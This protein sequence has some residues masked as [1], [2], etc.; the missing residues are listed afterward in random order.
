[1]LRGRVVSRRKHTCMLEDSV[2]ESGCTGEL[3]Q[4][5]AGVVQL[6]A[7]QFRA[8]YLPQQSLKF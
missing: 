5:L 7:I 8:L 4:P 2:G 1:M 3:L 6:A